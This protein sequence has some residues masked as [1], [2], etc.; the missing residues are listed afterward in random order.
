MN[1]PQQA[2][3]EI[4]RSAARSG[5]HAKTA[6][7]RKIRRDEVYLNWCLKLR[8]ATNTIEDCFAEALIRNSG[9][10]ALLLCSNTSWKCVCVERFKPEQI[11]MPGLTVQSWHGALPESFNCPGAILVFISDDGT[12][13]DWLGICQLAGAGSSMESLVTKL[14]VGKTVFT[15][16]IESA[17]EYGIIGA[18]VRRWGGGSVGINMRC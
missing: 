1:W 8:R 17:G 16:I 13:P 3:V 2:E 6:A 9:D 5:L 10:G 11:L 18:D 12:A 15:A 4:K 14:S 7:T